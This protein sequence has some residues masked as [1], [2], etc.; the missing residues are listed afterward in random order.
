V[1]AAFRLPFGSGGGG[2]GDVGRG[3]ALAFPF[4]FVRFDGAIRGIPSSCIIS[5]EVSGSGVN[6]LRVLDGSAWSGIVEKPLFDGVAGEWN[7]CDGPATLASLGDGGWMGKGGEV[8]NRLCSS[9]RRSSHVASPKSMT[10]VVEIRCYE[11]V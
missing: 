3:A 7:S 8:I 6:T 2:E 4:A 1:E 5:S 9:R 10:L 11:G